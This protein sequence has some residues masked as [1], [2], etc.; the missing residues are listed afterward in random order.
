MCYKEN[1]Q[2]I[3]GLDELKREIMNNRVF[4]NFNEGPIGFHPTF[5]V[6]AVSVSNGCL[7]VANG[8]DSNKWHPSCFQYSDRQCCCFS[9]LK[10][11]FCRWREQPEIS[12]I[13]PDY[14]HGVIESCGSP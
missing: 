5:K 4:Q 7:A 1:V 9:V 13:P 14:Q 11:T 3:L 12:G 2:D 10:F 6:C 8:C